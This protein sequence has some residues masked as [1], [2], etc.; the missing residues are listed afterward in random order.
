MSTLRSEV[1][2][3]I[4]DECGDFVERTGVP[5]E[6]ARQF[7]AHVS[8]WLYSRYDDP[9]WAVIIPQFVWLGGGLVNLE[10][11]VRFPEQV[12]AYRA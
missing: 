5:E 6:E 12:L 4:Y 2:Q 11:H 10:T 9:E 1:I 3:R 8:G 7:A